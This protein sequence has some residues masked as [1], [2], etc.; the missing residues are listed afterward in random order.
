VVF[1]GIR[2][3]WAVVQDLLLK[4][5]IPADQT[6][7]MGDDLVDFSVLRRVGLAIGVPNGHPLVRRQTD[8]V[9]RTPGGWGAVR[10]VAELLLKAQGHWQGIL[11]EYQV[12]E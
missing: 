3:K 12:K 8:Y 11:R 9:T 7:F 2:N 1:Q 6:A 5:E 10:E 4:K